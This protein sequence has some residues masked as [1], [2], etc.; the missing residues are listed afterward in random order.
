[1]KMPKPTEEDKVYLRSIVPD[2]RAV[3]IKPT[4][5][6]VAAFVNG[7]MFMG[8]FGPA[9][10]VRLPENDRD[11]LLAFDGAGPFGPEE[12]PMKEYVALPPSWRAEPQPTAQWVEKALDHTASLPP[13]AKK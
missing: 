8:L 6:N 2:H 1:M 12:R 9:V 11:E 10:G 5:G 13:K 4:F 7:N 3:E